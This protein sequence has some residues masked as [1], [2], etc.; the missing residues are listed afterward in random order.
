MAGMQVDERRFLEDYGEP[1]FVAELN[2]SHSG[3]MDTAKRM[4]DEAKR[5]GCDCVKFQSWSEDSLYSSQYY[6]ENPIAKRMFRKFAMDSTQ[7]GEI[8]EYCR[9]TGVYFTSTPYSRAEVDFLV[10][11][12]EVPYIKIA[13]MDLNNLP[14]LAYV[15]QSKKPIVLS[16]GMAEIDEIGR[17]L[18]TIEH[19][20]SREVCILHCVAMYPAD[21]EDLN[22]NNIIGLRRIFGSY[23]IGYSDHSLGIEMACASIA[24]GACM[25]EKHF[26]LDKKRLGLDNQMATEPDEM[27]RLV[28]SCRRVFRGLGTEERLLSNAE[29]EQRK[30]MRRSIVAARSLQHGEVIS[31][32]DL[33]FKRP[34]TGISPGEAA[35]LVGRT[36]TRD[37]FA[38]AMLSFDDLA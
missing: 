4:I 36:L 8:A 32:D 31:C 17:A 20:G 35:R 6:E 14:F 15:A 13:S 26:T 2:T 3:D 19:A 22:L 24:L 18:E 25:I 16:T 7:L 33:D 23:P 37:V 9:R 30:K 29:L 1:L 34:G 11:K 21:D 5:C 38:D 27:E 12:C 28:S 10:E